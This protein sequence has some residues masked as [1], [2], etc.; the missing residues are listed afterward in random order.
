MPATP[1]SA[2]ETPRVPLDSPGP[3][4]VPE[5]ILGEVGGRAYRRL[6]EWNAGASFALAVIEIWT[7]VRRDALVRWTQEN[8]PRT[9][10]VKLDETNGRSV[11]ALLERVCPEPSEA[12]ALLLIRLEEAKD[13]VMV[14]AQMNV[15]RTPLVERYRLPWVILAHPSAA[16]D[17]R[18]RAPDFAHFAVLWLRE[19]EE[20]ISSVPVMGGVHVAP[21]VGPEVG[22]GDSSL[23]G[24]A[25]RALALSHI[26]EAVDLLASYDLRHPGALRTEATKARLDAEL[27]WRTGRPQESLRRYSELVRLSQEAG[28]AKLVA[29]LLRDIGNVREAQG[30]WSA[31]AA[32][33][34]ES[35]DILERLGEVHERAVTL[36]GAARIREDRGDWDGA[37]ELYG[38]LVAAFAD[39]G[40]ERRRALALGDIAEIR[41][42]RGELDAALKLDEE[43]LRVLDALDDRLG[44]AVRLAHIAFIRRNTGQQ[45]LALELYQEALRISND[46]GHRQSQATIKEEIAELYADK[47]MREPALVLHREALRTFEEIGH[48]RNAAVVRSELGLFALED[49]RFDEARELMSAAYETLTD[50]G[51]LDGIAQVG[52]D[53]GRLLL[54]LGR[55]PEAVP[56]LQRSADAFD[57]LGRAD[58]AGQARAL[59]GRAQ[60]PSPP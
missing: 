12:S 27:L 8:L 32:A 56:I 14:C 2:E 25:A 1:A 28:D 58:L 59:L 38:E 50:L 45:D 55:N 24:Q 48:K 5:R 26:D 43:A 22:Q 10:V 40:D 52:L 18:M 41:A 17:F 30:D 6:L 46:I 16:L 7:P 9:C 42:I 33:Y 23:L 19:D 11:N 54:A 39:A 44:R 36:L 60:D 20:P 31:A 21:P 35:V 13:R 47:G 34:E 4:D 29:V 57:H 15:Q 49:G 37:L 3:P 53:L 51:A